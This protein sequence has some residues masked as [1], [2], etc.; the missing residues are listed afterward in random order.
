V[1]LCL[2]H[3]FTQTG[4]S[5]EPVARTL[6]AR[7]HDVVTPDVAG[8][9]RASA[10]RVDAWGAAG[11]LASEVGDAVWVGYSMGG[12]VALHVALA[13]RG[14]VERLV[15]VST[16]GGI[17]DAAER[18]S[19]QA[20]DEALADELERDGVEA[21][22]ERWL[23]GPLWA[24]LP[25]ERAGVEHRLAN[26]PGGLASSLR[27]AGTGAQEPLWG[28]LA[29]I[30]APVLVVTGAED[31]KFSALGKELAAALPNASL[32]VLPGAGHAVPWEQ[33]DAFVDTVDGWLRQ[34]GSP[35]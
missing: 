9:G 12:R 8:H 3:G 2:V 20:H 26:T 10:A 1:R 7:G 30:T 29:E 23:D 25:R 21:F 15:L 27:L 24:S 5:W 19:R 31:T 4:A 35:R 16:T 28:R 34:S 18:A 32:V 17:R 33:P 13:H 22:V 6:R 11:L 14:V